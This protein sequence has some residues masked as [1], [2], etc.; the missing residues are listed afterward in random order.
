MS[1]IQ[2][3]DPATR[4]RALFLLL[5][6]IIVGAALILGFES[7]SAALQEWILSDPDKDSERIIFIM[8][9][10]ACVTSAPLLVMGAYC[11]VLGARVSRAEQYP[12][13]AQLVFRDTLV[14]RG[15]A[16]V[17]RGNMFKALAICFIT[18]AFLFPVLFW[19]LA[20]MVAERVA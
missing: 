3:A 18:I 1:E 14:V 19:R 12:P 7:Y 10:S 2:K 5:I 6:G 15:P 20:V 11:W 9:V 17:R 13:P 16:A 4:R 8:L